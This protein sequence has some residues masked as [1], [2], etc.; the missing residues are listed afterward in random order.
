L[1]DLGEGHSGF[2]FRI[3]PV[4]FTIFN[5]ALEIGDHY[6]YGS[7]RKLKPAFFCGCLDKKRGQSQKRF[8]HPGVISSWA[9]FNF[10]FI[11]SSSTQKSMLIYFPQMGQNQLMSAMAIFFTKN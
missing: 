7:D 9:A 1:F 2:F 3:D 8:L 11:S 5:L 6:G 4:P 10:F